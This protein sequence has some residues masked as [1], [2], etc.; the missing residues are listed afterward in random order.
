MKPLPVRPAPPIDIEENRIKCLEERLARLEAGSRPEG[1]RVGP[2]SLDWRL[3]GSE[4]AISLS[5]SLTSAF[6]D[7]CCSHLPAFT[8]FRARLADYS[9]PTPSANSPL[10][11]KSAIAAFCAIGAR[12][13][14]HSALLGIISAP[15]SNHP[16]AP[17][18]MAGSR[19]EN[20]CIVLLQQAHTSAFETGL[21]DEAT[22]ENLACL[23]AMMQMSIFVELVP[24]KSRSLVR[25]ALGTFK[26]LQDSAN[27]AEERILIKRA[28]AFALYVSSVCYLICDSTLILNASIQSGDAVTS[29]YA[30][31]P[32]LITQSDLAAYFDNVGLVVPARGENL[33]AVLAGLVGMNQHHTLETATHLVSHSTLFD[34]TRV[35]INLEICYSS[36]A[37]LSRLREILPGSQ[38]ALSLLPFLFLHTR[39]LFMP[40]GS[41]SIKHEM[42]LLLFS[43]QFTPHHLLPLLL[44]PPHLITAIILRIILQK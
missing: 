5:R 24:K 4:M 43:K 10:L 41:Q 38:L 22:T 7:S 29:A 14:P 30:R 3:A 27:T 37:G 15:D 16:L 6:F 33:L 42:G 8:Y 26:E 23:L 28:F 25:A 34:P 12:A 20:A 18:V 19:R 31:K 39:L 35:C 44:L 36:P 40:Y 13:S 11:S 17:L 2:S 1:Q 32:C 9:S 21:S